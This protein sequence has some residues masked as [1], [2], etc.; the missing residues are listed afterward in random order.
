M[1]KISFLNEETQM[2]NNVNEIHK[3]I[4]KILSSKDL[5]FW[6]VKTIKENRAENYFI[7]GQTESRRQVNTVKY[8]ISIFVMN[9]LNDL[10]TIGDSSGIL[11]ENCTEGQIEEMIDKLIVSAK[12]VNNPFYEIKNEKFQYNKFNNCDAKIYEDPYSVCDELSNIISSAAKS[13]KNAKLSTTELFISRIFEYYSNSFGNS[14]SFD[15]TKIM[16]EGVFLAGPDYS[17]ESYFLNQAVFLDEL[18]LEKTLEKHAKYANDCIDAETL[19]TGKYKVIFSEEALEE[20]FSFYMAHAN[21]RAVYNKFSLLK[22]G[23][24]ISSKNPVTPLTIKSDPF[25]PG[26][27]S[28]RLADSYGIPLKPFTIIE[29]NKMVQYISDLQYSQYLKIPYTGPLT[30]FVIS[31]GNRD[32]NEIMDEENIVL[33][34]RFSAFSP[35]EITGD[36]SSEIRLGYINKNGKRIPIKGGSVSGNIRNLIDTL[37]LSSNVV[38]K[39]SYMGPDAIVLDNVDISGV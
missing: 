5:Y 33:L 32:L 23:E 17:S 9:K 8:N 28:S 39:G 7:F 1:N 3:I 38:K 35:K 6:S 31:P 15:R 25:V 13:I 21:A 12:L 29:N 11:P 19:S 27:I 14:Y 36:F 26:G 4:E 20:F 37:E 30:N 16:L 34:L 18:D 2:G 10:Q 24:T 22:L